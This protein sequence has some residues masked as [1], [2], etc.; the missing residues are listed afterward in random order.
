[1]N[2]KNFY[3]FGGGGGE[4]TFYWTPTILTFVLANRD[5]RAL[6]TIW[7]ITKIASRCLTPGLDE[8]SLYS[9]TRTYWSG[10]D[11]PFGSQPVYKFCNC[12][13]V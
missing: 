7:E 6:M 13:R 11:S 1:M 2:I 9:G 12:K 4:C 10:P 5:P 3:F 8:I